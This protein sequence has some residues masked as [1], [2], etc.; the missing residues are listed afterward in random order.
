[1]ITTICWI[2]RNI[3]KI[4]IDPFDNIQI[5]I[6]NNYSNNTIQLNTKRTSYE[7][8][9]RGLSYFT[10]FWYFGK[11][12]KIENFQQFY[13]AGRKSERVSKIY[14]HKSKGGVLHRKVSNILY[15]LRYVQ[16]I[17]LLFYYSISPRTSD[18]KKVKRIFL[19]KRIK[20]TD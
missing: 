19:I 17:L 20:F 14:F 6:F 9:P 3:D 13:S 1:M 2:Q 16:L 18:N 5:N 11:G 12:S 10:Y 7:H 15:F 8:L 4:K